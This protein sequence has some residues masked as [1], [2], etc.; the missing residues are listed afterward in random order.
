MSKNAVALIDCNNRDS[1]LQ[2]LIENIDSKAAK[3]EMISP[4]DDQLIGKM[5]FRYDGIEH[6]MF[7]TFAKAREYPGLRFRG[8]RVLYASLDVSES[9]SEALLKMC[10]HF[11]GYI[12][13]NDDLDIGY[14]KIERLCPSQLEEGQEWDSR[15]EKD[16]S[17]EQNAK[18]ER[19][20]KGERSG[21]IEQREKHD[22]PEKAQRQDRPERRNRPPQ[23][24]RNGAERNHG[25][26]NGNGKAN[27]NAKV[28]SETA[29][30]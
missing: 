23:K 7:F 8:N 3:N 9:S 19:E 17:K 12:N 10:K 18:G 20:P 22:R 30:S 29:T 1:L 11:G 15:I 27:G 21:K 14:E 28:K 2:F 24:Q 13:H 16:W 6:A 5:N 25:N 4:Y 26:Y